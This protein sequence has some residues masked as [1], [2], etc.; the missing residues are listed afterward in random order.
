[1]TPSDFEALQNN[2]HAVFSALYLIDA[3]Q[4]STEERKQHQQALSAAYLAFVNAENARFAQLG[5]KVKKELAT[6]AVHI[7]NM[8]NRIVKLETPAE[9]LAVLGEGLDN[10]ARLAKLL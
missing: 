7:E 4:L 5:T 3:D 8:H 2:V 1:M 10:L 6:L 9:Q